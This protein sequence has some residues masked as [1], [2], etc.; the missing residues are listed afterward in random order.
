MLALADSTTS[1]FDVRSYL[2]LLVL[3]MT[4]MF[5]QLGIFYVHAIQ[6]QFEST[7]S[8]WLF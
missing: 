6:F 7:G 3:M 2:L 1:T 8:F 4:K 5:P